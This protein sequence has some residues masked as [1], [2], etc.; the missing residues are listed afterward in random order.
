MKSRPSEDIYSKS[1][2]CDCY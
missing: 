1:T 2:M